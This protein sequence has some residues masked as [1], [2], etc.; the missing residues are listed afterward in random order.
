LPIR[1]ALMIEGDSDFQSLRGD[2]RFTA[3][4]ALA[5]ERAH[6]LEKAR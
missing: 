6:T 5:H 3:L 4:V 2:P 1:S